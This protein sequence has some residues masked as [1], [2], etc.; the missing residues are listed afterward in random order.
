MTARG[1]I[2]EAIAQPGPQQLLRA[3][4]HRHMTDG[5]VACRGTSEARYVAINGHHRSVERCCGMR[6]SVIHRIRETR[7]SVQQLI[8]WP[9]K[10]HAQPLATAA[11]KPRPRSRRHHCAKQFPAASSS[12]SPDDG[13]QANQRYIAIWT[14]NR[15]TACPRSYHTIPSSDKSMQLPRPISEAL[16]GLNA[17]CC[18]AR[19][20]LKSMTAWRDAG[21]QSAVPHQLQNRVGIPQGTSPSKGRRIQCRTPSSSEPYSRRLSIQDKIHIGIVVSDHHVMPS[22]DRRDA[23][24]ILLIPHPGCCPKRITSVDPRAGG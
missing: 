13:H 15:P 4:A 14:G 8:H 5:P 17:P 24:E 3:A 7:C 1:P 9:H 21:R 23:I 6:G 10:R 19:L 20:W 2:N 18:R 16:Q 11:T 22:C 12:P